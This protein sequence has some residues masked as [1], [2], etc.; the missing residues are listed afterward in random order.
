MQAVHHLDLWRFL[1][2]EDLG[3]VFC[4]AAAGTGGASGADTAAI[5]ASTSGGVRIAGEFC[6]VTGQENEFAIYGSEAWLRASLYR[7]DSFELMPR[8]A[9]GGDFAR[10]ASGV[11]RFAAEL[12]RAA[13]SIRRGGDFDASYVA[14]WRHFV[15]AIRRDA[16]VECGFDEG[17]EATRILLAALES[18][19]AGRPVRLAD[20]PR[21]VE[22]A[23]SRDASAAGA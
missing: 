23:P 4:G 11:G 12:A 18:A 17:R 13:P 2:A 22:L 19:Q 6:A 1:L 14:E 15:G 7:F 3:E 5:V 21:A 16:P 9:T 20:A 8:E 10:R